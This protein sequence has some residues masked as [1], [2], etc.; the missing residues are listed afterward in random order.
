MKSQ[1]QDP[2]LPDQSLPVNFPAF[3][4][5]VDELALAEI[6][7]AVLAKLRLAIGKD[8]GMAT[9]HDWYKAAALALRDR[10]V[11]RWLTAEKQSYDAGRK[12]VYYLSLEFLIGRLF[13]DALNNMGLLAGVRSSA[14][15]S[16]RRSGRTAQMRTRRGAR[17][18]RS[19]TTCSLL[20][21][22]HGDAG[23]SRHRLWHS[24]RF[25]PVPPDHRA[26]LATGISRRMARLRQPL[27]IPA[28]RSG[29]PRAF[30]RRRRTHHRCQ[31]PRARDLA[32]GGNRPG[33][34][35]RYPDRG[36]ARPARQRAAAV[37]GAF[38]RPAQARRVQ[39]RRLSRRQRRGGAR[40]IDL[41][42]PLSRTTRARPGASCGC[43]RNISSS[44]P[45][46]RT[47]SNAIWYPTGSCAAW[48]QRPRCSS[49]TPIPASPS[50]N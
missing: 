2:N 50:P 33:R 41:Q 19:G 16:R 7:G 20:H 43:G 31:R 12:R 35:L 4:Q 22:K 25:R 42:V 6:K 46:C 39:H 13:T 32:S 14:G 49:T 37:V 3:N 48:R 29:L 44:R 27:G 1:L 36:V 18:W 9:R 23:H 24:L 10:I 34:R 47:W 45:R 15:R 5:P 40:G 26:G 28:A 38:A 21:G 30:R 17:Q 11:H 8:A